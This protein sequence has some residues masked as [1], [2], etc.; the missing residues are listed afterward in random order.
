MFS[1]IG[2][3]DLAARWMGWETKWYSEIDPYACRVM[4]A[5]FGE[6]VADANSGGLEVGAK[7]N[8]EAAQDTANGNPRRGD[9][10]RRGRAYNVG[11]ITQWQPTAADA[12][13]LVCGGFPCQPVSLAGKGLAQEDERWL[14][15][16]FARVL[17]VLRP[18]YVVI[19]NVPGLRSRGMDDV[20]RDLAK[21]GYDTEWTSIR[22]SDAGAPHRRE[23]VWIVAYASGELLRN[24]PRRRG[25]P[26][27]ASATESRHDGTERA[28]ANDNGNS[29]PGPLSEPGNSGEEARSLNGWW[30]VEPNV[31]RVANGVPSRVDRLRCLGNAI[32]P[33]IAYYLFQQIEMSVSAPPRGT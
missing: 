7:R 15:P 17:G 6:D 28:V 19:E 8:G 13:G 2:G 27:R 22:A 31:G 14:W 20:L 30:T 10:D 9:F 24:E 1:G 16:E 25:G 18:R 29:G 5:R 3:F 23:R 12:V 26:S 21:I 4:E 33:Q 11:D 32:V